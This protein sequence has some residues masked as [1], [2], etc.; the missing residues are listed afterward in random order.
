MSGTNRKKS[1]KKNFMATFYGWG[2]TTSRVQSHY[3]QT[4]YFLPLSSQ[5]FL[6]LDQPRKDERLSWHWSHPAVLNMGPLNWESSA[7]TT[8]PLLYKKSI[9][10]SQVWVKS[11]HRR[12]IFL[13]YNLSSLYWKMSHWGHLQ[14]KVIVMEPL[15][16]IMH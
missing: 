16:L 1:L 2:W 6:V 13:S 11:V 7:L 5:K 9:S 15:R 3:E 12:L 8:R 4:V 10:C 14:Y